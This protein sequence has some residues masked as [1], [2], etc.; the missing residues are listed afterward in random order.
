MDGIE[1]N[2]Y[3]GLAG[4]AKQKAKEALK[5]K[6]YSDAWQLCQEE[7]TN[8]MKFVNKS[9]SRGV[10]IFEAEEAIEFD[11]SVSEQLANILRL[12]KRHR[13]AFTHILYWNI[14]TR[15]QYRNKRHAQKLS[16]YFNRCKFDGTSFEE[17]R[18][19][20][21]SVKNVEEYP[22]AKKKVGEW[23]SRK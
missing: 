13:E 2:P 16:A 21:N 9:N 10:R 19:F 8:Y 20:V 14:G 4:E 23:I 17:V 18:D 1:H 11:A 7:K 5:N 22:V 6:K 12:E 3:L 15:S